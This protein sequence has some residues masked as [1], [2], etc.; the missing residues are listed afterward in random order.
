MSETGYLDKYTKMY[1]KEMN[2]NDQLQQVVLKGHL[3]IE[4]AIENIISIVFF[5]PEY[6]LKGRFTFM[7]KVQMAR[8]YGLRKNTNPIWDL[9]LKVNEVRNEVA[10]N[11]I[12]EKRDT[13][14][15]QLREL[16]FAEA[17][18]TLR[19]D[20]EKD[21]TKLSDQPNEVVVLYSCMLC[22]GFLGAFEN[23][24]SA[25]RNY[26]DHLDHGLN[27]DKQRVPVKSPDEARARQR[28]SATE[29]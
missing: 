2:E 10:H 27:P 21:G 29:K 20:L 23:D 14:L 12:G 11:L 7:Q 5:H 3:I 16:F 15:N 18:D 25:L 8:A 6:V 28:R 9:I 13:K 22:T 4:A 17:T 24:I 19:A 26:I 1:E